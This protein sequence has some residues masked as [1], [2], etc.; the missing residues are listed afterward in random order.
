MKTMLSKAVLMIVLAALMSFAAAA[1]ALA[2][3]KQQLKPPGTI[4]DPVDPP[5]V[6]PLPPDKG[7]IRAKIPDLCAGAG[8]GVIYPTDPS[9]EPP[10]PP[11]P[12]KP[13]E[14]CKDGEVNDKDGKCV[15]E[16]G[17]NNGGG[18]G[19]N[20]GGG[21]GGNN[22][23]GY[24]SGGYG[25][26]DGYGGGI[27]YRGVTY[28]NGFLPSTFT[29]TV[30]NAGNSVKSNLPAP[31]AKTLPNTGGGW[32]SLALAGGALLLAGRFLVRRFSN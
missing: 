2:E 18:Y 31:V 29:T 3:E 19:G 32:T 27:V 14:T 21:Y 24:G 9:P 12:Q 20:N 15:P 11:E 4:V 8:G 7:S 28:I 1:P 5:V 10:N 16:H 17:G 30:E 6:D 26:D 13:P 22:G 23:G 25:G